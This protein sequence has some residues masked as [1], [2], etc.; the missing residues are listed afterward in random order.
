MM[1]G[2]KLKCE[3]CGNEWFQKFDAKPKTCPDCKSRYWE[4]PLDP[5]WK[6]V[7]EQNKKD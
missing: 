3:R 7:R 2:E 6:A 4:K 1:I 5:Y